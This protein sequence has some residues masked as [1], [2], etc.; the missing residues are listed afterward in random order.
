M[1]TKLIIDFRDPWV[2]NPYNM[3]NKLKN[4]LEKK[5]ESLIVK[6]AD[7]VFAN[8]TNFKKELTARYPNSKNK[9]IYVPNGYDEQDFSDM[10]P[11]APSK[12]KLIISHAGLLYGKRDP[13]PLLEVISMLYKT[14][15]MI[16]SKIV[17]HQIGNIDLNY[18]F[19]QIILNKGLKENFVFLGQIDHKSCLA[20]LAGSD[21]LLILQQGTKT[22]IPSKLYEYIYL[23]KPIIAI[24]RHDGA[25]AQLISTYNFGKT[26]EPHMRTELVDYLLSLFEIK[27]K[28]GQINTN[29]KNKDKFNIRNITEQ[30]QK[31]IK[32]LR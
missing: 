3:K 30:L 15:P 31:K 21:V 1:R 22:Q 26:F 23:E 5:C 2:N 6:K 17:F 13:L 27:M 11:I 12:N 7:V 19:Q 29:Y 18:N 16:A 32:Y 9:I 4:Y 25:L 20:H 24:T 28:H 14:H 8:T 10:L